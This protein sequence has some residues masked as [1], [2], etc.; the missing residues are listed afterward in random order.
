MVL[1]SG[2]MLLFGT[3]VF[4]LRTALLLTVLVPAIFC[5]VRAYRIPNALVVVALLVA[6]AFHL[7][8][9]SGGG[10]VYALEGAALG[11]ALFLPLYVVRAL[12]AGDVKLMAAVGAFLGPMAT[13]GAVLMTLLAG[14][15]LALVIALWQGV[16]PVV[17]ANT[18]AILSHATVAAL[19][20][21]IWGMPKPHTSTVKLPYAIAITAGTFTQLLLAAGG[22]ALIG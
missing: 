2:M 16:L 4:E 3:Y 7:F 21:S 15:V 5:D 8:N 17:L 14:G 12:G 1:D 9:A 13:I 19:S 10:L 18:R 20:G 11:F 6:V 22:R